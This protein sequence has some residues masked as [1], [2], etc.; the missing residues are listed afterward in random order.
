MVVGVVAGQSRGHLVERELR[1]D[2]DAVEG[3]LPVHCDI[4]AE[5]LERLA[6][7]GF[8]H[9]LGLLQADDVGPPLQEPGG[10]VVH[11]LLDRIDVP[12]GD[13][14][15]GRKGWG[16]RGLGARQLSVE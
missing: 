10:Q 8:V 7:E 11:S 9:A 16:W 4:V 14:H 6:R 15:R 1:Q 2:R 3:L 12:G 13:A 5:R